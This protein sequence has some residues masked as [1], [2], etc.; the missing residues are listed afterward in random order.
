MS[1][2]DILKLECEICASDK[3]GPFDHY[4]IDSGNP[5]IDEWFKQQSSI[6]RNKDSVKVCK[7]CLD[8]DSELMIEY[9]KKLEAGDF[10]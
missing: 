2:F 9:N 10:E 4:E 3:Y 1:W 6:K 8:S 5:K 7:D